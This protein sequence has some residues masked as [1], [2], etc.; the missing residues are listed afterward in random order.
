MFRFTPNERA[1]LMR[2]AR[3]GPGV[4]ETLERFGIASLAQLRSVGVDVVVEQVCDA[5]GNKAWRN[6]LRALRKVV[7]EAMPPSPL[8]HSVPSTHTPRRDHA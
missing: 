1:L 2:Q 6:R 3:I 5:T 8:M 7:S 4:V